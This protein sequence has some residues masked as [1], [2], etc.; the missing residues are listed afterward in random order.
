MTLMKG[1]RVLDL[2]LFFLELGD[3][4]GVR[5]GSAGFFLDHAI[6]SC[7]S[8]LKAVNKAGFHQRLSIVDCDME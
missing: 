5:R 3:Q 8:C 1:K 4:R 7:M 2:Q 6:E